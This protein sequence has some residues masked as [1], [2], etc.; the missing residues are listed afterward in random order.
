MTEKMKRLSLILGMA[1]AVMPV[2]A[3]WTKDI[4]FETDEGFKTISVY[5]CWEKSPFRDGRLSLTPLIVSNPDR[6]ENEIVQTIPNPSEKVA[7]TQRSRFGSNRFGLRIDLDDQNLFEL[8]TSVKYVHVKLLKPVEGRVM[9]VGLG[10]RNDVPDQDPFVEQFW[11]VS[12]NTAR[13]GVWNDMVFAIKGAGG[14]TM[15]SLVIV[16]DLESPHNLDSDFLFYV[17]DIKINDSATPELVYDYYPTSF[18]KADGKINRNDR[19]TEYV[20]IK[21]ASHGSRRIAINQQTDKKGYYDKLN[22]NPITVEPGERITPAIGYKGNWMNAYCYVDLDRNGRFDIETDGSNELMASTS[23]NNWTLPAFTIPANL[24]SG[25][26]RIRFKIDWNCTDPAGNP[27]PSNMILNN[28]GIVVDAMLNI[29]KPGA[30]AN[31][32]DFQLNGE[33]LAADGSKLS[34]YTVPAFEPFEILIAPE[35]GFEN[36]GFTI[37]YGYGTID[38]EGEENRFDRYGNPN[39]FI[40]D[41]PLSLFQKDSNLFTVP[42][43]CMFGNVLLQGRMAQVGTREE[44]YAV[45]FDKDQ[46][47]SRVDRHLNS[48]TFQPEGSAASQISITDNVNPRYV[49]VEKLDNFLNVNPGQKVSATIDYTGN[50]MHAYLYIDYNDNG[51]FAP[52][53]NAEGTPDETS[54]VV[55]FTYYNG[56]NSAGETLS[57]GGA[58][59]SKLPDFTIPA[60]LNPGNYRARLKIDWDNIDPAGRP[61]EEQ[62]NKIWDNGGAVLDFTVKVTDPQKDPDESSIE[63]INSETDNAD[64]T[65]DLLGRRV[66]KPTKGGVVIING[67]T[68]RL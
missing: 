19:Y 51:F 10:S 21:T 61:R 67:K 45:N 62:S 33:I 50:A 18:D 4:D 32:N 14:I 5:D 53:L 3:E 59:K 65:Y 34:N 7:G 43:E 26:Y 25:L 12:Q 29:V 41:F 22:E 48:V 23:G 68:T 40:R 16:P 46:T 24:E 54:E 60:D 56:K 64:N 63:E 13:P 27:D 1:A 6:N 9:L 49:Y 47:I 28:G 8:T 57:G 44:Y 30:T 55:S 37:K 17:D 58:F 39:W 31:A 42:A 66:L 36:N 2:N 35:N 52:T 11:T 38:T 15:R 20:E